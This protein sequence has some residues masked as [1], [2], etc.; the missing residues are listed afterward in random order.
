MKPP[1]PSSK[2]EK[3]I[4]VKCGDANPNGN[5][6]MFY[7]GGCKEEVSKLEAYRCTGCGGWFHLDCIFKHFELEAGHDFARNALAKIKNRTKDNVVKSWCD[8]G[9]QKNRALERLTL[10]GVNK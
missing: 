2:G 6:Y 4:V 8:Y 10:K 3:K 9:L 1:T 7:K 5:I